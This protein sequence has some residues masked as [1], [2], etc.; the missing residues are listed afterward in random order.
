[1][2]E[3]SSGLLRLQIDFAAALRGGAAM[4]ARTWLAGGDE[5]V[6]QGLAVYRANVVAAA[7]KA[8]SGAYPVI[9]QI[10]GDRFFRGLARE[11]QR[12]VPSCSGD[13]TDYG[14]GFGRF[15]GEFEHVQDLPYLPDLARLEWAVHLAHGAAD[16]AAW[17]PSALAD[18]DGADQDAIR[19]EWVPGVAVVESPYPIARLWTLHRPD[20]ADR[21]E[22]WSVDWG[23]GESA[24]VGRDGF[25]VTVTALRP[26]EAVFAKRSLAGEALGDAAAAALLIDPCFDLGGLLSSAIASHLICG[27]TLLRQTTSP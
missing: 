23:C 17:D 20:Q 11:F 4:P 26:A 1:M 9:R 19:F 3:P 18:I 5:R 25:A 27:C 16:G 8:L 24:L 12:A 22:E 7:E 6:E 13:L 2:P 14:V 21:A 15:L 10:V